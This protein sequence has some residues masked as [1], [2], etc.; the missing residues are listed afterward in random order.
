MKTTHQTEIF[1]RSKFF[2]VSILYFLCKGMHWQITYINCNLTRVEILNGLHDNGRAV[3]LTCNSMNRS[4]YQRQQTM[5]SPNRRDIAFFVGMILRPWWYGRLFNEGLLKRLCQSIDSSLKSENV[6]IKRFLTM[7]N[8]WNNAVRRWYWWK[9]IAILLVGGM[10]YQII[11]W[12]ICIGELHN[13]L[14]NSMIVRRCNVGSGILVDVVFSNNFGHIL[15][16][17]SW[18]K[19]PFM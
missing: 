9:V 18:S 7:M 6:R 14:A 19:T 3:V 12:N 5:V 13:S 1:T 4:I 8:L 16:Q 2:W 10:D 17:T 15:F 11:F